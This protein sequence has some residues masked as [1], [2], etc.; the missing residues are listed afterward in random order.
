VK[1]SFY[2][3][4]DWNNP[5]GKTVSQIM[6]SQSIEGKEDTKQEALDRFDQALSAAGIA[7]E[8]EYYSEAMHLRNASQFAQRVFHARSRQKMFEWAQILV[9]WVRDR[10]FS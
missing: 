7:K 3:G 8:W 5:L 10:F 6:G 2:L 4:I 9:V 1:P